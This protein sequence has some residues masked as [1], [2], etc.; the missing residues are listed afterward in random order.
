MELKATS[1]CMDQVIV[2]TSPKAGSG[3]KREQIPRLLSLIE[4]SGRP[5]ALT[6]SIDEMMALVHAARGRDEDPI[7]VAAGGDG[8]VS[9]VASHLDSETR[10]VTLPLGTENL[11]ARYFGY[12][13]EADH[14]METIDSGTEFRLDAGMANGKMFLGMV[15]CGFDAD[16]VRR[17][18]L[19]RKGHISRFSYAGP[20]VQS[21]MTYR[22]P[23]I[24]VSVQDS[25]H[26]VQE[27]LQAGWAMVF[28]LP[29]YGGGLHIEPG[30]AGDDGRLDLITFQGRS[31]MSGLA[32]IAAIFSGV[33]TRFR[34]VRQN[35]VV[36]IRIESDQRVPFQLDGD[37]AGKLPLQIDIA[38]SRVRLLIP[39]RPRPISSHEKT[40]HA[41]T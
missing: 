41:R 18:H 30:A 37:Y 40:T 34:G 22:F 39:L 12:R 25:E 17:L 1:V 33:H 26:N 27:V 5:H 32:Y 4:T 29:G 35:R 6:T 14:T 21:V 11:L 20:I 31:V 23:E 28:N 9:L 7:V 10:L 15:S 36:S 38:P 13:A 19:R 24:R 8:T 2:V 3:A 16:V